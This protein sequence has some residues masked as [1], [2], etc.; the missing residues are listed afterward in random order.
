MAEYTADQI[1]G[2]TLIAR[3]PVRIY[4]TASDGAT[5]VYTVSPG[6]P[7][8]TVTSYLL[9]SGSRSSLFWTFQDNNA[10]PYYTVHKIGRY[11]VSSLQQQGALTLAQQQQALE[12]KNKTLQAR[13]FD[14][15]RFFALLGAGAYIVANY[16][17]SRK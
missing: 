7:V 13:I 3:E 5:A 16:F 2:K 14:S 8:G 1:I 15:L 12:E 17:K 9:P 6:D 4:R 11:D 10:R